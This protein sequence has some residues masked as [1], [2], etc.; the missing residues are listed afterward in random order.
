MRV[1]KHTIYFVFF[2]VMTY[3]YLKNI[4]NSVSCTRSSFTLGLSFK[5]QAKNGS[6]HTVAP[7]F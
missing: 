3:V 6:M 2:I 5:K 4:G 1:L 7:S